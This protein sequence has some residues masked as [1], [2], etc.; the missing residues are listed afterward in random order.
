MTT[1]LEQAQ[2]RLLYSQ[3]KTV[4][5]D[6]QVGPLVRAY[7][8]NV[9]DD[10][11]VSESLIN[12]P[13]QRWH[14]PRGRWLTVYHVQQAYG[15]PEEGGWWYN[16]GERIEYVDVTGRDLHNA[17][18]ELVVKHDHLNDPRGLYSVISTGVIRIEGPTRYPGAKW[19]PEYRPQYC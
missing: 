6:P 7:L 18:M 8:N 16:V 17:T 3:P 15:G 4:E 12:A 9:F 2:A 14:G 11:W 19:T 10:Q 5:D 13:S 1:R